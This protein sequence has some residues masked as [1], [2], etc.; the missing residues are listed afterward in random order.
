MDNERTTSSK[1]QELAGC[2]SLVVVSVAE[3][4]AYIWY[5]GRGL[6]SWSKQEPHAGSSHNKD[7]IRLLASKQNHDG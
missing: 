1:K 2:P 5:C 4:L 3:G 6:Q 7:S